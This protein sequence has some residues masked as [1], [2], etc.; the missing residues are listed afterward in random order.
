M[1]YGK[2]TSN[3]KIKVFKKLTQQQFDKKISLRSL[4]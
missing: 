1:D 4:N 3:L 2:E